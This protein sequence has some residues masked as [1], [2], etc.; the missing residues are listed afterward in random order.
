[1]PFNLRTKARGHQDLVDASNEPLTLIVRPSLVLDIP[2]V[3]QK[4]KDLD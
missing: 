3:G 2:Y 4:M 1:M